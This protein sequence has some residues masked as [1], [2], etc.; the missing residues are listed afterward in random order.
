MSFSI[1]DQRESQKRERRRF[2]EKE[3]HHF[4]LMCDTIVGGEGTNDPFY[5]YGQTYAEKLLAIF[6]DLN[7][8]ETN[9][10]ETSYQGTKNLITLDSVYEMLPMLFQNLNNAYV[11]R[12]YKRIRGGEPIHNPRFALSE[13]HPDYA[14]TMRAIETVNSGYNRH[15]SDFLERFQCIPPILA[16]S[17]SSYWGLYGFPDEDN[18]FFRLEDPYIE[19]QTRLID[20][21]LTFSWITL[22]RWVP[23]QMR[24]VPILAHEHFHRV[25]Q[26]ALFCTVHVGQSVSE[27]GVSEQ[28]NLEYLQRHLY[29]PNV[30]EIMRRWHTIGDGLTE[31]L[32]ELRF[33]NSFLSAL[34]SSD[35]DAAVVNQCFKEESLGKV[36]MSGFAMATEILAD[37]GGLL[38]AGPSYLCSMLCDPSWVNQ[39]VLLS[40]LPMHSVSHPPM[41]TR[42]ELL[43]KVLSYLGFNEISEESE[44][45]LADYKNSIRFDPAEER[46]LD[47][48]REEILMN[49]DFFYQTTQVI[50]D[51]MPR[52]AGGRIK[53]GEIDEERWKK[54]KDDIMNKGLDGRFDRVKITPEEVINTIWYK[55]VFHPELSELVGHT[56]WR[57]ILCD[58]EI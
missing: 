33:P 46:I 4:K 36:Q 15:L 27:G 18:S 54:E 58:C 40:I 51:R 5:I 31:F 42:M 14:Q 57:T 21:F 10:S 35:P 30:V 24:N 13:V 1:F 20:Y 39:G 22:P 41:I 8:Y 55:M 17:P 44:K 12:K 45:M 50:L 38:I 29:G 25:L 48:F 6:N 3:I 19:T 23:V 16:I 28:E 32:S 43:I 11:L 56:A 37:I 7:A 2:L 47:E 53:R 52:C 49:L 9:S 26:L 34:G